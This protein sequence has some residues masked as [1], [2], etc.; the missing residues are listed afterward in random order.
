MNQSP[1]LNFTSLKGKTNKKNNCLTLMFIQSLKKL[2]SFTVS[3]RF[4]G[5]LYFLHVWNA[6]VE[7][8]SRTSIFKV[9][10]FSTINKP[11][12]TFVATWRQQKRGRLWV[13]CGLHG[14][15]DASV[16]LTQNKVLMTS[17][18]IM[19]SRCSCRHFGRCVQ[20]QRVKNVVNLQAWQTVHLQSSV[21]T[22]TRHLL[23]ILWLHPRH[24]APEFQNFP[25]GLWQRAHVRSPYW[26]V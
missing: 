26:R 12:V 21:P 17:W 10:S 1:D 25:S 6:P 23:Q 3:P 2:C 20:Q 24:T 19:S 15:Q 7:D 8:N 18:A 11:V 9:V 22:P 4:P 5:K 14:L 13:Y 16:N